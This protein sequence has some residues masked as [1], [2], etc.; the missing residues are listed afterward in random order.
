MAD[1]F[2]Q[3]PARSF[4]YEQVNDALK[5]NV[6]DAVASIF[7]IEEGSI[8]IEATGIHV[9]DTQFNPHGLN[10]WQAARQSGRTV[11]GRIIADIT[12][13]RDGKIAQ[14]LPGFNLGSLPLMG[15]LGT[16]MV[17]GSD[18][19]EPYQ[20]RMKPGVYTREKTNGEFESWINTPS[21]QLK[22]YMEPKTSI[23]KIEVYKSNVSWYAIMRA[24]GVSDSDILAVWGNDKG[25]H[26]ILDKNRVKA[27]AS[28]V[29]KMFHSVVEHKQNRDLIRAGVIEK[30]KEFDD[31]DE[32]GQIVAIRQWLEGRKLDAYTTQKTLG[33]P[34]NYITPR[35]FL[36]ASRRILEVSRGTAP[37]D[38]RDSVE[39]KNIYHVDDFIPERIRRLQRL[40]KRKLLLRIA[41]PGNTLVK[42][43]GN[44][45][46]NSATVSF[47]GG[48]NDVEGGLATTAEAANPLSILSENSKI[49][50]MGEGGIGTERAITQDARLFR[51]GSANFIDPVH[52]P[53]GMAVGVTTHLAVNAQKHGNE[54][55][56]FFLKVDGGHV[57]QN[58]K[59]VSLSTVQA[60]DAVIGYPEYWDDKGKPIDTL[61]RANEKGHIV[62]VD[63]KKVEYIIPSGR[64]MF[65]NTS[66][67][68]LFLDHT[69]ANRAMMAGKHLTQALPLVHRELPL[70]SMVDGA[71]NSVYEELAR[72]F[73]IRSMV[74][75]KVES[76]SPQAIVVA[77]V[78]HE[79]FDHYPMQAKVAL[80]HIP[81]VKVGQMVKKGDLLADSNYSRDGK[82]A[83]GVNVRTAFMPWKNGLNFEDAISISESAKEKFSSMH[84][85]REELELQPGMVIDK[86]LAFAQFPT[87]YTGANYAKLDDTGVVKEGSRVD[88]GDILVA[89]LRKNEFDKQD[90]SS[91]NLGQIHKSLQRPYKDASLVWNEDFPATV[92]RVLRSSTRIDVHLQTEEPMGVGDKLSMSSAAKGTVAAIIPDA[93]MPRTDD[94]KPIEVILNTHG[95]VNRINPSQTIEQ[96]AGLLVHETG[97]PYTFANFDGKDHARE[98]D[99]ALDAAGLSHTVRLFDPQTGKYLE[100]PV[101]V[102]YNYMVKLDHPVRKKFSARERDGY[103]YDETPTRGGGKGG[104]SYDHLTTYALLGHDAHAILGEAAGIR[105]TRNE[106][107]WR[108]YQAGET[109]PPPK[110]PFVFEKFRAFLNAAGVDTQQKGNILHY[111]P[112]TEKTVRSLSNGEITGARL[113]RSKDLAEEK[114]GLFDVAKTGGL[115]GDK[116]TH[117]ELAERIPHP[118]YEK[119]IRDMT[120]MKTADYYGLIMHTRHYDPRTGK[121][122]ETPNAHTLT[123]EAGFKKILDFDVDKK[124]DDFKAKLHTAVGSD[125]NKYSRATKYLRGLKLSK[126]SPFDAYMTNV[127]PVVPPKYRPIIEMGDKSLRIADSNLLY[128]DLVLTND[129]LK[130]AK[131]AHL[132]EE[133]MKAARN[134]LYTSFGALIGVNNPLTHR[135]DREDAS[136][137][138]DVIKGKLNKEG[139]F[140]RMVV[141]HRNDY[142]GRSTIEPDASLGPDEIAIPED[143]AWKL[144]KP[145]V[146]RRMSKG[147]WKPA[148]AMDHVEKRTMAARQNLDA[149]MKDRLVLY[150]RAPSLHRWSILAAKP[151]I[152]EGKEVRISP[153][154]VGPFNA[155]YD[156]DTMSVFVPITDDAKR[157]AVKLLPTNNLLYDKDKSLAFGVSKD[158]ISGIFALTKPGT[159]TGKTFDSADD[160]IDAYRSNKDSS[161]QMG[162]LVKIK[163]QPTQVAIG[164]LIFEEIVPARFMMGVSAPIDGKKLEKIL[165]TIAEKSPADYNNLSRKIAS[166]GFSAAAAAGGITAS[167]KELVVDR[168]K[169]DRLLKQL[170]KDV[171]N[172]DPKDQEALYGL[173]KKYDSQLIDEVKDHLG[174]IDLGYHSFIESGSNKKLDQ[175]KQML[176]SPVMVTDVHDQIVPGVIRSSYAMGM[177]PSDYIMVTPGARKG[178]VAKGLSVAMPGFLAKEIA[179]NMGDIRIMERDCGTHNGLDEQLS[180]PDV[181]LL[182][183]HLLEDV[184]GIAKRN[185]P[186]TPEILA[187]MRDAGMEIVRVRSPLTCAAVHVPCQMCAGRD[188]NG[189]L[190]PL[191]SNIG[192]NYGQTVSE[193]STQLML[194]SFHSGGTVGSGDSLSAGFQRLH[195]LLAVPSTIKN[196]GGLAT[197]TGRVT[198]IRAAPQGGSFVYIQ[199]PDQEPVEHHILQGRDV[200]VKHDQMVD[201]GQPISTGNFDPREIAASQGALAAQKYVVNQIRK[202]YADA[203]AVVRKPVI[204]VIAAGMMRTVEITDDG[205]EPDLAIGDVM[206]ENEFNLR[207][208]RN[209]KITAKPVLLGLG[210][211][212]LESKDLLSR[213]NFQRLDDSVRD[214]ASQSGSSDLT[215]NA[216]PIAGLAYGAKFRQNQIVDDAFERPMPSEVA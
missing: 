82:L 176:A 54:I 90:R 18:Y 76:V 56:S 163:G 207:H 211:K 64:A 215:G 100:K 108:A 94:G 4:R 25:A 73:V 109:P 128:R 105:G 169:I 63:P 133:H 41:K 193:R 85:H 72:A 22:V 173:S 50:V 151:R 79:L 200:I 148:E 107:F 58:D 111:L 2:A 74:D 143:M 146:V 51:P 13:S 62:M 182:D 179:G 65:D 7:P 106:D 71:G 9:D 216:S 12:L 91:Q 195:E 137:F 154:V 121:F 26:E 130:D 209:P 33:A 159:P 78:R 53:E 170:D 75:G 35:V 201:I 155:D 165:T 68:A 139:L 16:M 192:Y 11:G 27:R 188:A 55:R 110:V 87:K 124:L 113:I 147:G 177:R 114:G 46:L 88:P 126:L 17:K 104:Q 189:Q 38:D 117:I 150:N 156:G 174:K 115:K 81:V 166:A 187:K 101:G 93:E 24:L 52:S 158:V 102:G 183:R 21:G 92:Y 145:I 171:A 103:T 129:A 66:N 161:L 69:H 96:A 204:E 48:T 57:N 135:D 167:I 191:G 34:F 157:E 168:T 31:V 123:G 112:M 45:W 116:W 32:A 138:I 49:T 132:P 14:K 70:A 89:A 164:W 61:V 39:F 178:M 136:G 172:T 42:A 175:L 95:I 77:G 98:I 119:T 185:D 30:S 142:S 184:P 8:R 190:H 197:V 198:D 152:S 10:A 125:A 160:A 29:S 122:V 118:L 67:A 3:L 19:F 23:F 83:L 131:A 140:Q 149:E 120:G 59:P 15:A 97:K 214:V 203:G 84:I 5:K 180:E 36:E 40:L 99:K 153:L 6:I 47:F 60:S 205:G 80:D 37:P 44:G 86:K 208:M 210:Y 212:P 28:D 20:L 181:D 144:F 213:L 43:F 141:A 134:N 196:Q 186:V 202:S 206:H 194:K 162:S 1:P 127:V 199:A